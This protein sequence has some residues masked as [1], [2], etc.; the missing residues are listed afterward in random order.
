MRTLKCS[1]FALLVP[2]ATLSGCPGNVNV[3]GPWSDSGSEGGS[4]V[5]SGGGAPDQEAPDSQGLPDGA[6][7]MPDPPDAVISGTGGGQL[8]APYC[9]WNGC[10]DGP[11]ASCGPDGQ[12]HCPAPP[13]PCTDASGSSSG[14]DAQ[15]GCCEDGLTWDTNS[16]CG[17]PANPTPHVCGDPMAVCASAICVQNSCGADSGPAVDAAPPPVDAACCEDGL[18]WSG[19]CGT[20]V[21]PSPHTC[22]D[23]MALCQALCVGQMS[24]GG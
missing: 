18:T 23:P 17:T 7:C 22:G 14:G 2:V 6:V 4:S 13:P 9:P 12:W 5:D 19:C 11:K 16:C 24:C 10:L 3:G 15:A 8:D 1:A 20:M 21:N